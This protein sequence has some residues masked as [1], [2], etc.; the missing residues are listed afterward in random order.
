MGDFSRRPLAEYLVTKTQI[1]REQIFMSKIYVKGIVGIGIYAVP[2][3]DV[4]LNTA[5]NG[6]IL[7]I[8]DTP[9]VEDLEVDSRDINAFVRDADGSRTLNLIIEDF[10]YNHDQVPS[11]ALTA[12]MLAAIKTALE[13]NPGGEIAGLITDI[14]ELRMNAFPVE[15]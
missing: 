4:T 3:S 7:L 12:T 11:D 5:Q 10:T 9:G 14:E 1:F 6:M 8:T 13:Y 15:G 2:S